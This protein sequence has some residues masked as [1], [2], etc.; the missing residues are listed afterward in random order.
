MPQAQ[1]ST[2]NTQPRNAAVFGGDSALG[3]EIVA[4]LLAQGYQVH[5]TLREN[6]Q[7][8]NNLATNA[9][10]TTYIL[11]ITDTKK[12]D[13]VIAKMPQLAFFTN[14]IAEP[15]VVNRFEK[16]P[17]AAYESAFRINALSQIEIVQKFHSQ[18]KFAEGC[19][20]TFIISEVVFPSVLSYC[21]PY[22]VSK[23]ALLGFMQGVALELAPKKIYV[24]AISPGMMDTQFIANIPSLIKQ[25]YLVKSKRST[26][27]KPKDVANKIIEISQTQEF[28]INHQFF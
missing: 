27:I 9:N 6:V 7:T 12:L 25:Q 23:H 17:L 8:S 2:R 19:H 18:Q 26:F 24:N 22:M 11:D 13:D 28:G 20:I 21:M 5:Q 15:P 10:L 14:A 16:I 1:T 3:K 4:A